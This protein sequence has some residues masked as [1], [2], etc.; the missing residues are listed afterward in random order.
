MI[1]FV[2]F[3]GGLLVGAIQHQGLT[4]YM[5]EWPTME[6]KSRFIV[7]LFLNYKVGKKDTN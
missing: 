1:F 3:I 6:M 5:D 4:G 7:L 2:G